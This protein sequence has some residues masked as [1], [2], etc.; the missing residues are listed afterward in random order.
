MNSRERANAVEAVMSDISDAELI[1][2]S[3]TD[4]A[5][6]GLLFDRHVDRIYSYVVRR[7]GRSL[8]EELTAETFAMVLSKPLSA[9]PSAVA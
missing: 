8:A 6:F 5:S 2:A 3:E 1:A 4:G 9:A 7:V